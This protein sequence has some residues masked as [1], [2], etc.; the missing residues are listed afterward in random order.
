MNNTVFFVGPLPPPIHG[1]SKINLYV[2]DLLKVKCHVSVYDVNPRLGFWKLITQL[3]SFAFCLTKIKKRK[4]LYLALSGGLRQWIDFLFIVIAKIFKVEIFIHHHSFAYLNSSPLVSRVCLALLSKDNHIVLCDVMGDRLS[5]RYG[6]N[7]SM[8]HVLSNSAFVN[9][10]INSIDLILNA[11]KFLRVGFLSNITEAKGIF[12]FFDLMETLFAQNLPVEG[13]IA[14]PLDPLIA[15]DFHSRLER[16]PNVKYIGPVYDEEKTTFFLDIDLLVFPTRYVNEAEPVT[17]LEAL[18]FGIP[19]V[20]V[21]KGCITCIL[22]KEA[23]ISVPNIHDFVNIATK[24]INRFLDDPAYLIQLRKGAYTYFNML[25]MEH[26]Q[27]LD[28]LLM[29]ICTPCIVESA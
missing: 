14:G 4:T 17:I 15:S 21:A 16:L 28:T 13:L 3:C 18:S 20:A 25:R 2:L 6:I 29:R 1:F 7:R 23:G 26:A 24:E 8:I 19:V 27:H 12:D 9:P 10:S 11:K 5:I 22:P